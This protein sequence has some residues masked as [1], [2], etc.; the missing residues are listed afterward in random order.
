MTGY[1]KKLL[2]GIKSGY[3]GFLRDRDINWM[4]RNECVNMINWK[5]MILYTNNRL[6]LIKIDEKWEFWYEKSVVE[7]NRVANNQHPDNFYNG[8]TY[9]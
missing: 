9:L 5:N 2:H 1:I 4:L 3:L 7:T 6:K 8:I